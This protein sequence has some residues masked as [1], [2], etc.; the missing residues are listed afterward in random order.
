MQLTE[1]MRLYTRGNA[2]IAGRNSLRRGGHQMAEGEP[3]ATGPNEDQGQRRLHLRGVSETLAG[4]ADTPTYDGVGAEL[5]AVREDIGA[6][7]AEFASQLRIREPYL[8]AIED[9]RFDDLPGPVYAVGFIRS[10]AD[11]VGLDG[12][13]FVSRF[14][15]ES[16]ARPDQTRL[17]FPAPEVESRLPSG[18][19]LVLSLFFVGAVYAGWYYLSSVDRSTVEQIPAVPDRLLAS[20]QDS[21]PDDAAQKKTSALKAVENESGLSRAN[22]ATASI[23]LVGTEATGTADS[24][25][26]VGAGEPS[27]VEPGTVDANGETSAPPGGRSEPN[28]ASAA[29]AKLT[30]T[31]IAAAL[32]PSS[33]SSIAVGQ[34]VEPSTVATAPASSTDLESSV[35][36]ATMGSVR[37][38]AAEASASAQ[39]DADAMI[40]A[41]AAPTQIIEET[42]LPRDLRQRPGRGRA[43]EQTQG[44]AADVSRVIEGS[45]PQVAAADIDIEQPAASSQTEL[46]ALSVPEP[47]TSNS[48]GQSANETPSAP[49]LYG[50]GNGESR[51]TLTARLDSW[52][53]VVSEDNELLLTR[54]LRAGDTYF[55]PNQPGLLL[56]TG[57]AGA[58]Q[59]SVDGRALPPLGPIGAVRRNVSLDPEHLLSSAGQGAQ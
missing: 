39:A 56:L 47:P 21:A 50:D 14:K 41:A 51:V 24:T 42:D 31:K 8:G 3:N 18:R 9:G 36:S 7:R 30:A 25:V 59:V 45:P 58:L 12:E 52:V 34:S 19:L 54:I 28:T 20:T 33:V 57:N 23:T 26:P 49:R 16:A 38:P 10:Y 43:D 15:R 29:A 35:S 55:V 40:P 27:A 17:R 6:T 5:R 13:E 2:N 32:S 44:S 46:A 48:D 37:E 22:A 1:R 4:E 53:Q 11:A